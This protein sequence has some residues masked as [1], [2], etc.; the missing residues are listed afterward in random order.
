MPPKPDPKPP[1]RR[2]GQGRF[3]HK[4]PPPE[5]EIQRTLE[6][7]LER[8]PDCGGELAERTWHEQ[9]QVDL[10]PVEPEVV[11]FRTQSGYCPR[12]RKRVRACHPQQVSRATGAAGVSLGPRAKALTADLKHRLGI[13]YRKITELFE[14][15]FGLEVSP[16]GLCQADACLAEKQERSDVS[17][18]KHDVSGWI[19][20]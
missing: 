6:V 4:E 2:P 18:L 1:G 8:C 13:P 12:C 15:A 14:T 17:G 20:V 10:P 19:P 5:E 3:T 7:P 11:R 16:G 9:I